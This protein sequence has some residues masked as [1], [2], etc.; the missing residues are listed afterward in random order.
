MR[1][2]HT[3]DWHVGKKIKGISRLEEQRAVLAEIVDVA[4][5]EHA[6]V[7][8][9]AGDLFD[10][11]TPTPE[12]SA[13]VYG[14]LLDLHRGGARVVVLGGNHD[15][16]AGLDALAPILGAA[17]ITL[18]GRVAR[19]DDGGV[20]TLA[21]RSGER[22]VIA[23]VPFLSQRY[24]VRA[25]ALMNADAAEHNATY[26]ERV[27]RIVAA[28][29]ARFEADAV[30][31]VAA[32][33]MIRGGRLGGGERDAQ[34][35]FEYSVDATAFPSSAHYIALGHLHRFQQVGGTLPAYYSGSPFQV[36]FGESE[37]RK[38]VVLVDAEPGVPARVRFRPLTAGRRLQTLRGTVAE[39]AAIADTVGDAFLRVYVREPRR[40]GL[41]DEV[42][43]ILPGA[44]EVRIDP[45]FD[46]GSERT[47]TERGTLRTAHELFAAYLTERGYADERLTALFAELYEE[48]RSDA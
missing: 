42:R 17:G 23:L 22:A 35:I 4:A 46:A 12:M 27:R 26:D 30:N 34:T 39:L 11:A 31:I 24:V 5:A 15:N 21:T 2:L 48:A 16:Q 43:E 19:A 45:E 36:D 25:D 1:I 20:V 3:S 38:G 33:L 40:I 10:N 9:V 37:D 29:A 41:A 7:V 8:I 28:L 18:L 32:H 44:V 14:T 47:R 6:D 13:T